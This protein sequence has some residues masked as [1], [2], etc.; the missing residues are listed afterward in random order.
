MSGFWEEPSGI[1]SGVRR[2]DNQDG[3]SKEIPVVVPG[4]PCKFATVDLPVIRESQIRIQG[5]A[6]YRCENLDDATAI[7]DSNGF[8]ANRFIT[9]AFPLPQAADAFAAI[10][11]GGKVKILVGADAS[12]RECRPRPF[13]SPEVPG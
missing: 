13:R 10:W 6:S 3:P 7:V 11:A 2:L 9:A 8:D 1:A 12:G 5:A 4:G